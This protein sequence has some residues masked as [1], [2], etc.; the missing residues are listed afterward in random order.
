MRVTKKCF[1]WRT[2]T[3]STHTRV[4]DKTGIFSH[5]LA[6]YPHVNADLRQRKQFFGQTL[7]KMKI[8]I[9]SIFR[10][11]VWTDKTLDFIE[12]IFFTPILHAH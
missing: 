11:C 6:C 5:G 1:H 10:V 2:E 3:L 12:C 7:A 8:C 4:P 9:F